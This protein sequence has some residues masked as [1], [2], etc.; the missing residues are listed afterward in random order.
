M[1]PGIPWWTVG[2]SRQ[3]VRMLGTHRS[4]GQGLDD[5]QVYSSTHALRV[6]HPV[7]N[8]ER[9][10]PWRSTSP[11]SSSGTWKPPSVQGRASVILDDESQGGGGGGG[12]KDKRMT[13]TRTAKATSRRRTVAHG[14]RLAEESRKA[15]EKKTTTQ[16]EATMERMTR[17][18]NQTQPL[19]QGWRQPT[20]HCC[21]DNDNTT[22]YQHMIPTRVP[23]ISTLS[24]LGSKPRLSQCS[25][26][27]RRMPSA[28]HH[29]PRPMQM[30]CAAFSPLALLCRVMA[31]AVGDTFAIPLAIAM[32]ALWRCCWR[33][34]QPSLITSLPLPPRNAHPFGSGT[35]LVQWLLD[36]GGF[37]R[38]V[39]TIHRCFSR[40]KS[41]PRQYWPDTRLRRQTTI[42][43]RRLTSTP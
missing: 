36:H 4:D 18:R 24:W 7:R 11:S 29:L 5:V 2:L 20:N 41:Q 9:R 26:C 38:H 43:V 22:N 27:R 33:S 42:L 37:D 35:T 17:T 21:F 15:D 39:M 12:R 1:K 23:T 13:A 6:V 32:L 19:N 34:E 3:K 8:D 25:L 10:W 28:C 30:S 14:V 16:N 31:S 40:P